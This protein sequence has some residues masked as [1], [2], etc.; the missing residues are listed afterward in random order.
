[1]EPRP[2]LGTVDLQA[3]FTYISREPVNVAILILKKYIKK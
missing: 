1:M 2:P 3:S